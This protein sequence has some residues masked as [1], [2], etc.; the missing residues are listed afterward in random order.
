MC[1]RIIQTDGLIPALTQYLIR[2]HDHGAYWHLSLHFRARSQRQRVAHPLL[3]DFQWSYRNA[4][5]IFHAQQISR[6]R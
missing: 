1:T 6:D 2:A 4:H 5:G 3:I